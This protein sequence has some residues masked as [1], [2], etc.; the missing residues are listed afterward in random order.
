[1]KEKGYLFN[2]Q[3]VGGETAEINAMQFVVEVERR[4]LNDRVAYAGRKVG[5]EKN[6]FFQQADIF[7]QQ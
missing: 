7:F 4:K 5:E 1:M 6:T 2:C 3:Y